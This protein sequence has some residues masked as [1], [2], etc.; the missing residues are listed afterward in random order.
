MS[1]R[2]RLE[3]AD[4]RDEWLGHALS[5]LPADRPAAEAAISSLYELARHPAP[6]FTWVASPRAAM[7]LVPPSAGETAAF[8][9]MNTLADLPLVQR[10]AALTFNLRRALD[11]RVGHEWDTPGWRT[12][13]RQLDAMVSRPLQDAVHRIRSAMRSALDMRQRLTWYGQHDVSWIAHYDAWR[14][15]GRRVYLPPEERQL[16]LWAAVARS[17]G[18]WWAGEEVCVISERPAVQ[19][20]EDLRPHNAGGPAVGFSDGFAVHAWH[21]TLVPEWVITDPTPER[22]AAEPNV[23]VRRCA[24]ENLG[25]E[26]YIE[27]AELRMVAAA[28]DPGN[29]GFDL[30][31]YDLPEQTWGGMARVLLAVN[32][33]AERDGS[34]RRYGLGVPVFLD[35]PVAAAAWTYGLSAADYSTLA[36]RT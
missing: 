13:L 6:R 32:G 4:I 29:P 23:E 26:R 33:S 35:D 22:I 9:G 8:A 11:R 21:G 28:A 25:W 27:L 7:D 20:I 17:C 18:W 3:A 16:T 31:L 14:R 12:D 34:R 36:R 1:A 5:T 19:R 2:W 10:L 24:I 15:V 30:L